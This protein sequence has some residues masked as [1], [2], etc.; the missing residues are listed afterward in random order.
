M[1]L[2]QHDISVLE[3]HER[4]F[5]INSLSGFKSANL[6]GTTDSSQHSNLA[7]VSS[8]VHLGSNPPLLGMMMRPSSAVK[9]TLKNILETGVYTLNHVNSDIYKQAHQASARYDEEVSEFD[10]VGLTEQWEDGFTAPFVQESHIKIGMKFRERHS[11]EIN[12]TEFIIGEI[13]SIEIP[14]DVIAEDGFVS[15]EKAG[16]L[17]ISSLDT[18]HSTNTLASLSYAKPDKEITTVHRTTSNLAI[19]SNLSIISTRNAPVEKPQ[20]VLVLAASGGIGHAYCENIIAQYPD[21]QLIRMARNINTLSPLKGNIVDIE[22]DLCDDTSIEKSIDRAMSALPD[23][24]KIDWVFIASGWLHDESTKPEKTYRSLEREHLLRSYNI[25]AVGPALFVSRLL[26]KV[27]KKHPIKIGILSA[28]VGSISDN[29]LGGWH[30][31][32][33]SKSALHML[34]KNIAIEGNNSRKAITIVGLQPGTTDTALSAPFQR[35]LTAEQL[36]T[37]DFTAK[38]LIKV[39]SVL[40]L[41]DSG[42]L[43]DLKGVP[44]EP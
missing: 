22:V 25:N 1:K 20:S 3:D 10:E 23:A 41:K 7:I 17:A 39:M 36:Q 21:V 42:K 13:V 18:Y 29:R 40:E 35:G 2:K 6:V 24:K 4:V 8:V 14:D 34:I 19:A 37:P 12:G 5:F 28:R 33:A 32:R 16:T 27:E 43:F 44:F 30:S 38:H 11:L 9:G 15:L 26:N 31:Y